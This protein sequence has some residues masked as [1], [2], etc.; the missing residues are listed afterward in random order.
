MAE[1]IKVTVAMMIVG[2]FLMGP[3]LAQQSSVESMSFAG[4][5]H[6]AAQKQRGLEQYG[7][8]YDFQRSPDL[9]R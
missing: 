7:G 6:H 3:V 4:D 2:S 5:R 8:Q 9:H 1:R